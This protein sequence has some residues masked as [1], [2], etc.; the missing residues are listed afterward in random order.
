M[1]GEGAG[2]GLEAGGK[3]DAVFLA[4]EYRQLTSGFDG[5][6]SKLT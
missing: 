3:V 5:V 1:E 6:V 2:D 4:S